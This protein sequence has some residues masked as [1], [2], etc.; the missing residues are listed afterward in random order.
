MQGIR[1]KCRGGFRSFA[2]KERDSKEANRTG[3]N[4]R[5][6]LKTP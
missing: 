2:I 4:L 3:Y 1:E 5:E 6:N